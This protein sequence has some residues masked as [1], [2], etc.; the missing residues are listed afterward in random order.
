MDAFGAAAL[1]AF[2]LHLAFN[3]VVIKVTSGG[4]APV[5]QAGLRSVGAVVV[6]LIWMR[7]RGISFGIPRNALVGGIV[8]GLLFTFEFL[9]LYSALDI[10]TVSRSSVIFYTMPVWLSLMA[11]FL[12]PGERLTIAKSVGLLL[13]MGGVVIA[14]ADRGGGQVSWAGDLMALAS[15][16]C[17]AGIVLCVRLTPLSAVP[18]AQQLL[19]QVVIS[20]PILLGLS[21]FLGPMMRDVAAIHVAGLLFQIV[22]VASLGFLVW[23]W[24]MSI[25]PASSVASFSF[26]SPV[27]SVIMGWLLLSEDVAP[28]VW[29][30]LVLVATGIYLINRKPRNAG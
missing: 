15:A 2:A 12:F 11:H 5:F 24:L 20:A 17:W 13:A 8:S 14:L 27:A 25:Y 4:F 19:F 9:F 22:A 29:G 26:L 3:Q 28:S 21:V 16:F 18:P 30:A 10:S 7:L 6:L 1:I 23:F